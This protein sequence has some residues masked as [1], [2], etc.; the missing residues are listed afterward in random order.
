[1]PAEPTSS[2]NK[3]INQ[4]P[5]SYASGLGDH[6]K[7]YF[8]Y[9]LTE[10]S[11]DQVEIDCLVVAVSSS[12]ELSKSVLD[13]DARL[14]G[15]LKGL[16]ERGSIS[17]QAN[18]SLLIPLNDQI[19]SNAV[20]V[21]G[22]GDNPAISAQRFRSLVEKAYEQLHAYGMKN[23][24]LYLTELNV[25]GCDTYWKV[26]QQIQV[27][28]EKAYQFRPVKKPVIK[29]I[30]I[31]AS[32][33]HEDAVVH[34]KAFGIAINATR[35]LGDTPP[36]ICSPDFLATQAEL[37]E[38]QDSSLQ[39]E[40]LNEEDMSKL[41][42]NT[43]LSV[44][45]GSEEPSRLIVM[46]YQGITDNNKDARAPTVLIG[47]GVTFD[48]GGTALKDR[49]GMRL[50][51]YDM[52]GAATVIGIMSVVSMLRLP[53]NLIGICACAENM[54]SGKASR[55][56]DVVR[57]M[58]GKTVEIINPDA[59][60]RLL[61]C[62]ALTYAE[63]FSPGLVVD[64]A[65]LT[66]ASI[67]ALGN[68]YSAMFTH[69]DGL[70]DDLT[71]AG[72]TALDKVWRLPLSQEDLSQLDSDYADIA[73]MGNGTAGCVVAALF[74]SQFSQSYPWV[75][76]DVS[77][78]AKNYGDKPSASGRPVS[79]LLQFLLSRAKSTLVN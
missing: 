62:D 60:G 6:L 14:N 26:R 12:E 4:D 45:R 49:S 9:S 23:V 40:V 57:S 20:L 78:S 72:E 67:V 22:V 39:V 32:V 68:H 44:G 33:A 66:G 41:G 51:K 27:F 65:T 13:L 79:L 10:Q 50:M 3:G 29:S 2:D 58:S 25:S 71:K 77:G 36:N 15:L 19:S 16:L 11:A 43:M 47:K 59:E 21:L 1:M 17:G 52:C 35:R 74:L 63:R 48:T 56:S 7:P 38:K 54:P 53:I 42:M 8:E 18:T 5:I 28:E 31:A 64:V 76:L 61:L 75:H 73:N 34:G 55:P 69:D 70:S 37:L 24:G 46:N 30:K